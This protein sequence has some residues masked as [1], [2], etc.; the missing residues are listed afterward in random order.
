MKLNGKAMVAAVMMLGSMAV[1]GCN[2]PVDAGDAIAP[3][4]TAATAPV[5]EQAAGV[6]QN[7]LRFHYG[8]HY[9]APHAPPAMRHETPGRAP[10]ARH[11]WA[12]GYWRWNGYQH[13]WIGGRWEARRDHLEYVGPRWSNVGRRWE[14]VPGHW[15]RR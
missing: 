10:S 7:A 4:E 14:Y 8:V 1:I 6:E 2:A 9:Y 13:V 5:E 12:P 15:I 11:F 3:E